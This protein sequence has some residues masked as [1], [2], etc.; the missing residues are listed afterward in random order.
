VTD[1][2]WAEEKGM[3]QLAFKAEVEYEGQPKT[4]TVMLHPPI[5]FDLSWVYDEEKR[6]KV[7]KEIPNYPQA[8]RFMFQYLKIKLM[9]A[10]SGAYKFEEEFM[11]DLAV[12]TPEG[13]K[14]FAEAMKEYRPGFLLEGPAEEKEKLE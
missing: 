2:V 10:F 1:Y 7:K 8:Y 9:A 4:W 3:V 5:R 12:P 6:M 14:R 13:L 11:A